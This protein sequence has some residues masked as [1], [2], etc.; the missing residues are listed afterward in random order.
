MRTALLGML[1]P[2]APCRRVPASAIG[3]VLAEEVRAAAP[4]PAAPVAMRDGWA[5]AAAET[6]GASPYAPVP[7][8]GPA[9][10]LG[11]GQALPPGTDALLDPFD[12]DGDGP[13]PLALQQATPGDG[14]RAPGG[15]IEAGRVIRAAGESLRAADLPALAAMGVREV[16]VRVPRLALRHADPA[17]LALLSAW[18]VAAGAETQDGPP[19]L[20]LTQEGGLAEAMTGMGARPG[21]AAGIGREGGVPAVLLPPLAED[22]VAAWL[23]LGLPALRALAGAASPAPIRAR[24]ARKVA[25]TVGLAELVPLALDGA[26]VATPLAVGALPLQALSAAAAMLVVPPGAEGYEAGAEIEAEALPR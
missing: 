21:M 4:V 1:A 13:L 22:A 23:L 11:P 5:V 12:M 24:L 16:A 20:V 14:V 17:V 2:V 8:P 19:D 9:A 26:G 3:H 6:E 15:E 7:L 25:S 18:A 10:R